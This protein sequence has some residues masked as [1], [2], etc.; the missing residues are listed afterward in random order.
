MYIF[1]NICYWFM[2][3]LLIRDVKSVGNMVERLC[4]VSLDG[5]L[6]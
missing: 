3:R 4:V 2:F 5:I 6:I 1:Y